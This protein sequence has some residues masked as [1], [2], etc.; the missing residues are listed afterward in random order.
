MPTQQTT[1]S[2]STPITASTPSA[3]ATVT[4]NQ[5]AAA[6]GTLVRAGSRGR[7]P[8]LTLPG[9]Q[10]YRCPVEPCRH[11]QNP[12][13]L[14]AHMRWE[15]PGDIAQITQEQFEAIRCELCTT[16]QNPY[17]RGQNMGQHVRA[18]LCRPSLPVPTHQMLASQNI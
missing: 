9:V 17:A 11:R 16:C 5:R 8:L 3:I 13:P 12:G 6:P 2:P 10:G 14:A 1:D 18:S 7:H 15:H 4:P